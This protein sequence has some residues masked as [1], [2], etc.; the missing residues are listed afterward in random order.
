MRRMLSE[1]EVFATTNW[2]Y[3]MLGKRW[4]ERQ[5]IKAVHDRDLEGLLESL[6][7]AETVKAGHARCHFCGETLTLDNLQAILPIGD[8][9]GLTC[10]KPGCIEQALLVQRR[11]PDV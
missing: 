11:M 3:S 8:R 10:G 1:V 2:R 6:G 7:L 4:R 9:I 5:R